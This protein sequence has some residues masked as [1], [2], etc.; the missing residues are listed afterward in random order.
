MASA[1]SCRSRGG[2]DQEP[3]RRFPKKKHKKTTQYCNRTLIFTYD[4]SLSSHMLL[5]CRSLSVVFHTVLVTQGDPCPTPLPTIILARE[6]GLSSSAAEES[7]RTSAGSE[8]QFTLAP[9]PGGT[10]MNRTP[11]R[12]GSA[13][14]RSRRSNS[15]SRSRRASRIAGSESR[16]HGCSSGFA[17]EARM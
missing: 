10:G 15:R 12:A 16:S 5:V 14:F 11:P 17:S 6:H 4:G 1:V 13:R 8:A 2:Q 9:I 7:I 3:A